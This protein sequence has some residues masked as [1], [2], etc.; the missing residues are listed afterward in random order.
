MIDALCAACTCTG[1]ICISAL[2]NVRTMEVCVG[3]LV[4]RV[5]RAE[6]HIACRH[7]L[8]LVPRPARWLLLLSAARR[9]DPALARACAVC[10]KV[11]ALVCS[12]FLAAFCRPTYLV[13]SLHE[14]AAL[15]VDVL[16]IRCL[17]TRPELVRADLHRKQSSLWLVVCV[18]C[19]CTRVF[20]SNTRTA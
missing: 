1:H 19:M 2:H 17:L 11:A 13:P 15:E 3:Q 18:A 12:T 5:A 20:D 4:L 16:P 9:F 7:R 14:I 10:P 8:L 6:L